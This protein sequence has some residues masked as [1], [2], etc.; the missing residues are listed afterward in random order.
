MHLRTVS[1]LA[2]A[3]IALTVASCGG[4]PAIENTTP[5]VSLTEV[6][7]KV[8]VNGKPTAGVQVTANPMNTEAAHGM[9]GR[10]ETDAEGNYTLASLGGKKGVPAGEFVL[11]FTFGTYSMVQRK[12]VDDKFNGT[13]ADFNLNS[14]KPEF[15]FIVTE[16]Q[17]LT[18]PPVDLPMEEAAPA[19]N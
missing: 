19:I 6:S 4:G 10:G 12:I 5:Q 13:Y 17:A 1:M 9:V 16:G 18:V 14:G 7:G 8:T 15:K 2:L 11:T 3:G